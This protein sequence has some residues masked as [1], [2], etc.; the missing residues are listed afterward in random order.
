MTSCWHC[1]P[2]FHLR[3]VFFLFAL[4]WLLL[5]EIFFPPQISHKSPE[6]LIL[7]YYF[8]WACLLSCLN[9]WLCI[10]Y[11]FSFFSFVQI[12]RFFF[13]LFRATSLHMEVPKLGSESELKPLAYTI[14]IATWDPSLVFDPHYSSWQ[15]Q[16]PTHQVRLRIKPTSPW[17][18][19]GLISS[20]PQWQIL[21]IIF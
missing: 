10:I 21:L 15:Y 3:Q 6:A 14:A 12:A 16:I 20:A 11:F 18:L 8:P 9:P 4:S 5:L 19:V 1:P 17:K 7:Y 2:V 13:F